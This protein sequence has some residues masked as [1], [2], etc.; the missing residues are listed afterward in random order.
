MGKGKTFILSN[1]WWI[2][3]RKAWFVEG[4]SNILFCLNLDT[5]ECEFLKS[6]PDENQSTLLLNPFCVKCG[7][8]VV[9]LPGYGEYIWIYD[10]KIQRFFSINIDNP[11]KLQLFFDFWIYGNKIFAVS[12]ELKKILEIDVETH[13]IDNCYTVF[14]KSGWAR[15]TMSDNIIY[16]VSTRTNK[17]YQFNLETKKAEQK[18]LAGIDKKLYTICADGKK[19]WMSGYGKEIY[20]WDKEEDRL[21]TINDFPQDFGIYHFYWTMEEAQGILD[22][23]STEY[24][25]PTF[26]YSVSAGEYIW[27]IPFQTNKI[28]YINKENYELC[29]FEIK[30][31]IETE[32]TLLLANRGFGSKYLLEYVEDNRYIGLYSVKNKRILEIDARNLTYQWLD[33]YLGE[34]CQIQYGEKKKNVY[35]EGYTLDR[36]VYDAKIGNIKENERN[37]N[38]NTVGEKIYRMTNISH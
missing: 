34:E 2:E 15:S 17:I 37:V 12:G 19:F 36:L 32:K 6:I 10:L 26:L 9:C 21:L 3:E 31:E 22:C 7:N 8:S 5:N 29:T 4:L 20:V 25:L 30:E 27:F 14:E 38:E 18:I 11:D 33:Y 35:Y 23:G 13:Q 16:S 1:N 28:I 24:D